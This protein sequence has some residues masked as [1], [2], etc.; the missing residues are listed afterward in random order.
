MNA[1]RQAGL[2]ILTALFS[3]AL[4]FGSMLL[5]LAEGGKHVALLP[6]PTSTEIIAT[7]GPDEPTFTPTLQEPTEAPVE[8]TA[9]CESRPSGWT[10]YEVLPG[11]SLLEI[12]QRY[13]TAVEVLR[14]ANCLDSD[15]LP[16]GHVLLVPPPT[17]SP[18]PTYTATPPTPTATEEVQPKKAAPSQKSL[19]NGP[20]ANWVRYKV[21]R[22]DTLYRI[23]RSYGLTV[24]RLKAENCL[25]SNKIRPGQIIN[26]PNIAPKLPKRTPTPRSSPPRPKKT[27]PPPV[28][29]GPL[30]VPPPVEFVSP[31]VLV[32]IPV[33]TR[34]P[35]MPNPSLSP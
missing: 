27:L 33:S 4:V 8:P 10:P 35:D 22:G 9:I 26:V 16:V 24:A 23:A 28:E 13:G 34:A 5:A 14:Q 7:L 3:S 12:A 1:L 31:S 21:K 11:E 19:C 6:T 18:T 25:T 30:P 32:E 29:P 15:S 17:P 2:G 20:P